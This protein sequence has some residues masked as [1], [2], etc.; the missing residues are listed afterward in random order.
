MTDENKTE[1]GPQKVTS[2][3]A[4]KS[5]RVHRDVYLPS[6]AIVD[7]QLPNIEKMIASGELPNPLVQAALEQRDASE[8]TPELLERTWQFTQHIVPQMVV[9]PPISEEDVKEL[10][11]EDLAMLASFANRTNDMDALG[12]HLG[13]LDTVRRFREN[14]GLL[15]LNEIFEDA[16]TDGEADS[17]AE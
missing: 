11:V 6:G 5:I 12:Q 9:T 17:Q 4:W 2:A 1:R 3:E 7:I 14:R 15:S 13:G 16:S 10:P 8:I